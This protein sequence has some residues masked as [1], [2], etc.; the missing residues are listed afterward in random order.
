MQFIALDVLTRLQDLSPLES[1]EPRNGSG[2]ARLFDLTSHKL[3]QCP[4]SDVTIHP[5]LLGHVAPSSTHRSCVD[6]FSVDPHRQIIYLFCYDH[7]YCSCNT[8]DIGHCGSSY[9]DQESRNSS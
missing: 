8:R 5:S 1:N 4:P 6:Y 2:I 9:H 7:E 3:Y